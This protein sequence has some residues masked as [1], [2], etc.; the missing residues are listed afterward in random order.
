MPLTMD[1]GDLTNLNPL[2]GALMQ[3]DMQLIGVQI[4]FSDS[5]LLAAAGLSIQEKFLQ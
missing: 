2:K 4:R 5:K 1:R 3:T